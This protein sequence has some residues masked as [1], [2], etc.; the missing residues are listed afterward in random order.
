M[1]R[2]GG[3]GVS[4]GGMVRVI[5]RVAVGRNVHVGRGVRVTVG[6]PVGVAVTRG[7][8]VMVAVSGRRVEVGRARDA[9]G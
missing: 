6:V 8:C 2:I 3:K 7:V 4:V 1:G 5:V 9:G